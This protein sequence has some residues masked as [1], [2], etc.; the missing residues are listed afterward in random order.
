MNLPSRPFRNSSPSPWLSLW[1][2]L[3]HCAPLKNTQLIFIIQVIEQQ[4]LLLTMYMVSK[5][6]QTLFVLQYTNYMLKSFKLCYLEVCRAEIFLKALI[7]FIKYR[8]IMFMELN[9]VKKWS[10]LLEI[11]THLNI[12]MIFEVSTFNCTSEFVI[13]MKI[14]AFKACCV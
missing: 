3:N 6:G 14:F 4:S 2:S 10:H 8:Y 9:Y 13:H 12:S 1:L 5:I 11:P 7:L